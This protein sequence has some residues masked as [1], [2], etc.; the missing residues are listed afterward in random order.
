MG[1][2]TKCLKTLSLFLSLSL[3][4]SFLFDMQRYELL[5]YYWSSY[6]H[7]RILIIN[8]VNTPCRT[9]SSVLPKEPQGIMVQWR[10]N[11]NNPTNSCILFKRIEIKS[12]QKRCTL[13]T[14][15]RYLMLWKQQ[16]HFCNI[17]TAAD[18]QVY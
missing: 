11:S 14:I 9:R 18:D 6:E 17:T 7:K 12:R 16:K 15:T 5:P 2:W 13:T 4:L 10:N 3:L 1:Y 8:S